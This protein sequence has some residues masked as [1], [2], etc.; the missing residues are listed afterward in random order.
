MSYSG[1]TVLAVIGMG[2]AVSPA[3]RWTSMGTT[4]WQ[5]L[6]AAPPMSMSLLAPESRPRLTLAVRR[7]NHVSVAIAWGTPRWGE[8]V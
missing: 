7:L 4:N 3:R 5:D 2:M 1:V 6:S 8:R